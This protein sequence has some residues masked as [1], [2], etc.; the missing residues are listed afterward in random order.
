MII[1]ANGIFSEAMKMFI[2]LP[3]INRTDETDTYT[4]DKNGAKPALVHQDDNEYV[5]MWV[6]EDFCTIKDVEADSPEKVVELAY[7]WCLDN[8][9]IVASNNNK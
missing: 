4:I 8:N 3:S 9:L 5:V 2:L 1:T 6:D 7:N